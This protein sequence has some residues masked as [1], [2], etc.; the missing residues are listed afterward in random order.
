MGSHVR[1][2]RKAVRRGSARCLLAA[3]LICATEPGYASLL[4]GEALDKA[5]DILT[6]LVLIIVP[7][8]SIAV[9]WL[10]HILPEKLAQ[11]RG[12]P[13]AEAIKVLCLLSL[14]FGGLLWPL[15]WLWTFTKPVLYKLA[16]GRDREGSE[17]R[18]VAVE[19]SAQPDSPPATMAELSRL[20]ARVAALESRE[21]PPEE[22]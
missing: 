7:V 16:Y 19:A 2:S 17:P 3:A 11:K 21:R 20:G 4:G 6:I 1:N 15:A 13:Q 10:V 9:F 12:H 14:V 8:A 18:A 22:T 5:A